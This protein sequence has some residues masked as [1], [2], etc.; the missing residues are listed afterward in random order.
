MQKMSP[1]QIAFM[2]E[3]EILR[4]CPLRFSFR[5]ERQVFFPQGKAGNVLRGVLGSILR[6]INLPF[7]YTNNGHLKV[8][9]RQ[10]LSGPL[11]LHQCRV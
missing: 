2:P 10:Q 1:P 7:I 5:A 9:K 8:A 11:P 4:V 6:K 3:I